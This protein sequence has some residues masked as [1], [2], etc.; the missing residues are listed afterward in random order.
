[1]KK[2]MACAAAAA[3]LVVGTLC[4]LGLDREEGTTVFSAARHGG[5]VLVIDAGHGGEDGGAVSLTGA[6]ESGSSQIQINY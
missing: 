6:A 3:A 5:S 4:G 1:M 2:R